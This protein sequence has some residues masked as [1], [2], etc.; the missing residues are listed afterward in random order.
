MDVSCHAIK[1][2]FCGWEADVYTPVVVFKRL[3]PARLLNQ[4]H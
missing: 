4:Y 2:I 3:C 1:D